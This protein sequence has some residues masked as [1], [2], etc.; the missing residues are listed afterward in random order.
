MRWSTPVMSASGSRAPPRSRI[1]LRSIP[2][3]NT[4]PS[5]RIT[6]TRTSRC[7]SSSAKIRCMP[8]ST[9]LLS[10]LRRSGRFIVTVATPS[11]T[12][13]QISSLMADT[14]I[15]AVHGRCAPPASC[16]GGS[17]VSRQGTHAY[18]SELHARRLVV[19]L[20]TDVAM[21]GPRPAL[22]LV[23]LLPRRHVL[24]GLEL[25]HRHAVDGDADPLSAQL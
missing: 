2:E 17:P 25:C 19:I 4:G 12:S 5:P 16:A 3:Q 21:G 8:W 10:A 23:R 7:A 14:L 6:T 20:Q 15:T 18:L 24:P 1:S 9:A 11:C 13:Y 22:R